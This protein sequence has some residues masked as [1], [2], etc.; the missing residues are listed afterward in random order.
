[1]ALETALEEPGVT[2]YPRAVGPYGVGIANDGDMFVTHTGFAG[3]SAYY[4]VRMNAAEPSVTE[5]NF[6]RI[7]PGGTQ[8]VAIGSRYAFI[9][10]RWS[11]DGALLPLI[12]AVPRDPADTR[13]R[14]FSIQAELRVQSARGIALSADQTRMYVVTRSSNELFGGNPDQLLVLAVEGADTNAP[15]VSLIRQVP[16]PAL[17]SAVRLVERTG[18]TPLLLMAMQGTDSLAIYDD[19]VGQLVNE[20]IGV[21]LQPNQLAVDRRE[22]TDGSG[23]AV[24]QARIYISNFGDGRVAVLDLPDLS[25]PE[26]ARLVAHIGQRQDVVES[27]QSKT[28]R[29]VE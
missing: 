4:V 17:P 5:D 11:G 15:N 12:L 3:L 21:G 10:S 19:A 13:I 22:T 8:S 2:D 25:R 16:L 6:L 20:V 27:Q 26:D 1:L 18:R 28:C 9:T 24:E 14:S 23:G 7:P 29:M